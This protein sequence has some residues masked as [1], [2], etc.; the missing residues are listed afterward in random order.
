MAILEFT[1]QEEIE[2]EVK[3]YKRFLKREDV[4]SNTILSYTWTLDYFLSTYHKINFDN[5]QSYKNYLLANFAPS[6]ANQRMQAM[7]KYFIWQGLKYHMKS[8]KIQQKP[9]LENVIS[10]QDYK[11]L[12][13]QLK[14][15]GRMIYYFL[16]WGM[17][18][19]GARISEILKVKVE[20]IIDGQM[21]FYG[22][23][24]KSR[25]I[26]FIKAYQNELIA[27]LKENDIKSGF[28]FRN[29]NGEVM[30]TKGVEK[31]IKK[32]AIEYGIDEEVMYP[33][34][35]RHL[36]GKTFYDKYKDL[37]LLADLMGHSSLETTRIYT[38]KT[39]LEQRKIIK[40]TVI[41]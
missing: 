21:D 27:Y 14:K 28:I 35:F 34:S 11:F 32:F 22:K 3:K 19:T 4:S 30:T 33:H 16:I 40:K 20:N 36:F 8:V 29:S 24:K 39:S 13:E 6:T 37:P 26:Y 12:K 7:N 9:F 10:M 41:W 31:Q 5:V 15:D 25:R 38:R 17:G 1:T 2:R 18:C 23:G